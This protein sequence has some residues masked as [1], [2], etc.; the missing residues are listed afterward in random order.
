MI[1]LFVV[2]DLS[3]SLGHYPP[4]C[5]K[6]PLDTALPSCYSGAISLFDGVFYLF[7]RAI[8]VDFALSV[9]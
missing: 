5:K 9:G 1:F 8:L 4:Y 2:G 7:L 3:I 6:Y